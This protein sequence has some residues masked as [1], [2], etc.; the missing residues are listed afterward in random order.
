MDSFLEGFQG[1]CRGGIGQISRKAAL[2]EVKFGPRKAG[3]AF[4]GAFVLRLQTPASAAGFAGVR[5]ISS[6]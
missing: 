3:P 1:I 6:R 4:G 2:I 5:P